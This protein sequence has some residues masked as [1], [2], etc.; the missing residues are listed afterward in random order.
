[1]AYDILNPK[2]FWN[3]NIGSKALAILLDWADFALGRVCYQCD[4]ATPSN[5]RYISLD[6]K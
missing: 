5:L 2:L 4:G 6:K 3:C 1:M